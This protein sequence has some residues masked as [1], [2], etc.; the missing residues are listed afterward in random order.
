MS[1]TEGSGKVDDCSVPKRLKNREARLM[2]GQF[3]PRDKCSICLS[4]GTQLERVSAHVV[5]QS[6]RLF[7]G[8]RCSEIADLKNIATE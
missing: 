3:G 7:V 8:K 4:M 2:A 5:D 1:E 6:R